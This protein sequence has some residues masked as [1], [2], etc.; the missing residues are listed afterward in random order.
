MLELIIIIGNASA[1]RLNLW[2]VREGD[3]ENEQIGSDRTE[4]SS[5]I[6]MLLSKLLK[7]EIK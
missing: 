7:A 1:G 2:Y 5:R 3:I 6:P 4:V